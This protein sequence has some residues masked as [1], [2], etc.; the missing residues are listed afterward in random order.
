MSDDQFDPDDYEG[1]QPKMAQV[2]RSQVRK[3]EKQQK[4]LEELRGRLAAAD[5]MTAFAKAGI[6]DD[7]RGQLFAKAYDGDTDPTA[8]RQAWEQVFPDTGA[9][10]QIDQ[11]LDGHQ[12]AMDAAS[13]ASQR[14]DQGLEVMARLKQAK[15]ADEVARIMHETGVMV[16]DVIPD[17]HLLR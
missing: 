16:K 1:V 5:R 7:P 3:W 8:I 10:A 15:S 11:S 12:A 13:G 14:P 2:P 6:P 9:Q 4:E 17:G